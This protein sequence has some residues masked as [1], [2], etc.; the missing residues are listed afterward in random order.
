MRR[1]AEP[2]TPTHPVLPIFTSGSLCPPPPSLCLQWTV[3]TL[4]AAGTACACAGSACARQ[5]GP[6]WAAMTRCLPVR[7][8]V[9]DTAPISQT[10]TPAP[11]SPAG[12]DRTASPVREGSQSAD[13]WRGD[14]GVFPHIMWCGFRNEQSWWTGARLWNV[15]IP[16]RVLHSPFM[17][18]RNEISPHESLAAA[19]QSKAE[20][21]YS[22]L[23]LTHTAG[24]C[25]NTYLTHTPPL[26]HTSPSS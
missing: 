14:S 19:F 4:S 6:E 11:A 10:Q 3:W 24:W 22:A 13:A 16:G 7:S 20:L 1:P 26:G 23:N 15:C 12:P 9:R 17:P 21:I 8:N 18:S 5:D 2:P 25:T